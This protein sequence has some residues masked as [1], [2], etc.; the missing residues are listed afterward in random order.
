MRDSNS[1]L[2]TCKVDT[3][4]IELTGLWRMQDSNLRECYAT[5]SGY[6]LPQIPYPTRQEVP[7]SGLEPE[8]SRLQN[9]RSTN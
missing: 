2:S 4:T 5:A 9:E 7:H 8:T 3:L 6:Q 1:Q